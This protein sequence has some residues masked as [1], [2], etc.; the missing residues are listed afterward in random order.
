MTKTT[1]ILKTGG[2][3]GFVGAAV[4]AEKRIR[5]GNETFTV[6]RVQDMQIETIDLANLRAFFAPKGA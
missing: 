2:H 4:D 3:L 6:T 5:F 1:E